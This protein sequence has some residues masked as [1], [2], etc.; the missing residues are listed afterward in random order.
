MPV[1]GIARRREL[2]QSRWQYLAIAVLIALGSAVF[3]AARTLAINLEKS[4]A[5]SYSRLKFED[6]GIRVAAAPERATER[7]SRI[8][9]VAAVEGRLSAEVGIEIV[10]KPDRRWVGRI[11]T[12][13]VGRRPTVN[14]FRLTAGRE[15]SKDGAREVLVETSFARHHR[16]ESGAILDVTRGNS[17]ARL[18]VVGIV[19]SPEFLYVVRSKQELFP[20]QETFGVFFTGHDTLGAIVGKPDTI[21]ELRI[22]L[23]AQRGLDATMR[24]VRR[25]LAAYEP[26]DPVP[27]KDQ[28]SEA[29][30]RQDLQ[31]FQMYS[32]VFPMFF[33][34]VAA[35]T[36]HTLLAR[37]VQLQ[38]PMI[39]LLRSLGYSRTQVALHFVKIA[40]TLGIIASLT[41][42]MV[43]VLLSRWATEGYM[44]ELTVPYPIIEP[45]ALT[46]A[47]G[48]ALGLVACVLAAWTPARAAAA[49]SP[50]EALRGSVEGGGRVIRW[51][52]FIG[53]FS[54][55]W[56]LPI[57]NLFRQPRRTFATLLGV[58]AGYTLLL[59]AGSLTDTVTVTMD[60]LLASSFKEDLRVEFLDAQSQSVVDRVRSWPGVTWAE[61][62]L[63]VPTEFRRGDLRYTAL[64]DGMPEVSLLR[65]LVGVRGS[66]PETLQNGAIFGPTLRRRLQLEIGDTVEVSRSERDNTLRPRWHMVRVAGFTEEPIGTVAY[67]PSDHLRRLFKSEAALPLGAITGVRVRIEP[68]YEAEVAERLDELPGAVAVTS[69]IT[70]RRTVSELLQNFNRFVWILQLFGAALA[71]C[72][73]FNTVT[74]SV[75]ERTQECATMRTL[76]IARWQI[77][78]LITLE[79]LTIIGLGLVLAIPTSTWFIRELFRAAQTP[80]QMDLFVMHAV[81][82]PPS[83]VWAALWTGIAA[84][85]SQ[86]PAV[87]YVHRLDLSRSI[88]QRT[89]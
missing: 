38:R 12:M 81:I 29:F 73:L 34:G 14:D 88:K 26:D 35:M 37:L 58:V 43:G 4:Y 25:Q 49:T 32:I 23:D 36:I 74:I 53:G 15:L 7:V 61:G 78:G 45:D 2:I 3:Q 80:E 69:A 18:Q 31:G 28:P 82:L 65:D 47:I 68:R 20:A 52:R 1:L 85:L 75:L 72:I 63:A 21:N 64:L 50:A 13:P 87:R 84:M 66:V 6:F 55:L 24:E 71:F 77:T 67:L 33:L 10:G 9:G 40:L 54:I 8:P 62:E 30:L 44:S 86:I 17:R 5:E 46:V 70:L 19:Q 79:T 42:S 39:G 76:G 51:D 83:Y 59:L 60:T 48:V 89:T 22:R 57:R 56:R 11:I 27:R 41:G 16:L